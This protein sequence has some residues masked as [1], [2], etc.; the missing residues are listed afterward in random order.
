MGAEGTVERGDLIAGRYRL[1]V[2]IGSGG[3]G[4]L[5]RAT[6]QGSNATVALRRVRLSHLA[7]HVQARARERLRAEAGIAS[8]LAHPHIVSVHWLVEHDGE[9][10]LVMQYVPASN[11][12]ELTAAG[13]FAP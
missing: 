12:A 5:W 4:E 3:T 10:W 8:R 2:E 7:P 13:P 1:D 9:P 11:L 6:E